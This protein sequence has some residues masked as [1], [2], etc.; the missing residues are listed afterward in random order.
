MKNFMRVWC[1]F[2]ITL[3]VAAHDLGPKIDAINK[4]ALSLKERCISTKD[5]IDCMT[6]DCC[7]GG[8]ES[9]DCACG[10]ELITVLE[11]EISY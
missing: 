6:T 10:P 5:F 7:G 3:N 1:L 11:K 9:D 2:A 4:Q 8:G